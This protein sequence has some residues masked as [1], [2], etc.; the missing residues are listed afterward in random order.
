MSLYNLGRLSAAELEIQ[1][2]ENDRV[3]GMETK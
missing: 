2:T 3:S 1:A